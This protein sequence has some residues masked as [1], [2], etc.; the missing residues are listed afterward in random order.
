MKSHFLG[1]LGSKMN[2]NGNRKKKKLTTFSETYQHPMGKYLTE[3]RNN[4]RIMKDSYVLRHRIFFNI[5]L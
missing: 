5:Y 3:D 2:P 1:K 4:L